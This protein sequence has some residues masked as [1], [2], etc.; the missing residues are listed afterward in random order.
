MTETRAT[1]AQLRHFGLI[2]GGIFGLIGLWPLVHGSS[3]RPWA[4]GLAVALILPALVAP[5]VLGPAQRA[6]MALGNALGW[7]NTRIVLGL[8]FFGLIT[9]MGLVF[10]LMGRDPMQRAFDP[11]ATT[12]RVPRQPRPGA[13]ML[14]Q[15]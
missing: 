7:L 4:I 15:F 8:I 12:Y 1:R 11:R 13:H 2:V 10:R 9:P 3:V 14:R 5:R 6:W